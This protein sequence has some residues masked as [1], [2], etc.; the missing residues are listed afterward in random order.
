MVPQPFSHTSPESGHLWRDKWTTLTGPLSSHPPP[1]NSLLPLV[2]AVVFVH[3][4]PRT[5]H[6]IEDVIFENIV[7]RHNTQ[8]P[9]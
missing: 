2:Y 1:P 7:V 8:V 6:E 3:E 9:V 5:P 4:A